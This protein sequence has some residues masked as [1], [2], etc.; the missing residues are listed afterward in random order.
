MKNLFEKP[1]IDVIKFS[2][3]DVVATSEDDVNAS[4]FEKGSTEGDPLDF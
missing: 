3:L 1:Y 2:S 4:E